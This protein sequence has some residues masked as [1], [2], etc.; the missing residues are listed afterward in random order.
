MIGRPYVVVHVAVSV[1]GATT[2]LPRCIPKAHPPAATAT[3]PPPRPA[4]P[5]RRGAR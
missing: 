4:R 5:A 3:A 2:E 1:E